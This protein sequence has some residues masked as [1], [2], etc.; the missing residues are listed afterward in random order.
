ME[1]AV[2]EPKTRLQFIDMARSIAIILMLEG[3]FVDTTLAMIY[4][5]PAEIHR[6]SDW[7]FIAY[8]V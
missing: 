6:F 7:N 1:V 2:K 4:R 3:H 5:R 8:D